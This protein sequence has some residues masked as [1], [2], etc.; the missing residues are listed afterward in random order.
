MLQSPPWT[1]LDTALGVAYCRIGDFARGLQLLERTPLDITANTIYPAAVAVAEAYLLAGRVRDAAAPVRHALEHAR[2]SGAR[3][4]EAVAL[5]LLAEIA[6]CDEPSHP[7]R[8]VDDYRA[9]QSLAAELGMRPLVAHCHLGL[10]RLFRREEKRQDA[11]AHLAAATA[12]YREMDM[13]SYLRR[14]EAEQATD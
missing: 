8:A 12:M 3:G 6:A 13:T 7:D 11:Q 1:Q 9:A 2:E 5:H 4:R 10:G 14:A